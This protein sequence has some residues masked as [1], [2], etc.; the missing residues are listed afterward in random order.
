[1]A[2]PVTWPQAKLNAPAPVAASVIATTALTTRPAEFART[3][4]PCSK[5]RMS[6][7]LRTAVMPS[8]TMISVSSRT[9]GAAAEL[10]EAVAN[11]GAATQKT[12]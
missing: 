11:V 10:P 8:I 4:L 7:P 12:T 3:S 5:W 9:T 2:A 6:A 1:M